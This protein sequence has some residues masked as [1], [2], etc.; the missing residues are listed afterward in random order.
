M[1]R[2]S[3]ESRGDLDRL[4]FFNF[5]DLARPKYER[6]TRGMNDL[7]KHWS[8]RDDVIFLNHGSYGA[9]PQVVLD[10]QR[11]LQRELEREPVHF[12]EH[13]Y[14]PLLLESL[15]ALANFVGAKLEDLG[16]VTCATVGVNTILRSLDFA[17]GD[18]LLTTNHAYNACK[19]VLEFVAQRSGA[20]VVVAQVPFPLSDEEQVIDA[21]TS[22][23]SPR[24]KLAMIDHVTSPSGLI[25]PLEKILPLFQAREIDVLV[26]GAHAPGMFELNIDALDPAYYVGNCHKWMCAP[27]GAAFIRVRKDR[28]AQ[29][30]P[31]ALSHGAN[32]ARTD[33]TFF[34]REFDWFGTNDPSA[35]FSVPTAIDTLRGMVPGGW[36]EIYRRNRELVLQGRALLMDALR[37]TEE[38]APDSMIGTLVSLPLPGA[39]HLVQWGPT[40]LDQL[41]AQLFDAHK[42]EVPIGSL[43]P[44]GTRV[45]RIS[46][47][48]HNTIDD[49]KALAR[50]LAE[51]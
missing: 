44:N 36:S 50:A 35:V 47:H 16:F 32:S 48:L 15:N 22:C 21:I 2:S 34:Q 13:R 5:G 37:L 33:R 10:F 6:S 8:L 23:I 24:T 25:F 42:I 14:E 17:P 20:R 29:I 19:N 30:R 7:R 1:Q 41:H 28:Q 9:C 26:D 12:F 39:P 4:G 43:P 27:K 11:E 38:P 40:M 18:E 46:A 3:N 49:Y 51:N 31:L 45:I